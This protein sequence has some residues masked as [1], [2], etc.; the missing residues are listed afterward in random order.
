MKKKVFVNIKNARGRVVLEDK[1]KKIIEAGEDPF[2]PENLHKYHGKPIIK[3]YRNWYLTESEHPY[4][5][6]KH[7]FLIISNTYIE[8]S[9][10]LSIEARNE[11][12]S[13]I[14]DI[15]K[16]NKITGYG[17]YMRNG[18]SDETGATVKRLHAHLIVP[19][20][21]GPGIKIPLG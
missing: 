3:M 18:N 5:G 9:L 6:S 7:H 20:S 14:D 21:N 15:V 11:I 8:S 13:I 19:K 16:G 4:P 10:E 2:D 12:F 1:L 17:F